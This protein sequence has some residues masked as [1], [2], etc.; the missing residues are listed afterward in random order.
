[1]GALW[2]KLLRQQKDF[3]GA[4]LQHHLKHP[5]L[6]PADYSREYRRILGVE[7]LKKKRVYLDM[8]Y[9]VYCL[10]ALVGKPQKLIHSDIA[11]QLM[12]L[13]DAG[14]IICPA[15]YSLFCEVFKQGDR[16]RRMH[17][18]TLVDCLSGMIA[19]QPPDVLLEIELLHMWMKFVKGENTVFPLLQLVWQPIG[20]I[21]G[22]MVPDSLALDPATNAALKKNYYD[23]VSVRTLA[24]LV[25]S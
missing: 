17:M 23:L 12:L 19:L 18:A 6:S 22:E 3:L 14:Q 25:E 11:T 13:V 15:N 21:C 20:N 24:S 1:M 7:V 5:E 4:K 16:Q 2:E 9:W 8:K 10:D